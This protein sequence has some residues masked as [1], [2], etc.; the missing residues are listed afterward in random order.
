MKLD[1]FLLTLALG[2]LSVFGTFA[3]DTATNA[4]SAEEPAIAVTNVTNAVNEAP[5]QGD[6]RRGRD[7]KV[8]GRNVELRASESADN[9]LVIGGSARIRGKVENKVIVIGGDIDVD[10]DVGNDVVAVFGNVRAGTNAH[11]HS[12]VITAPGH[13]EIEEGAILNDQPIEF[14]LF[15][16][17]SGLQKWLRYCGFLLRPMAP[18]V[19]WVWLVAL[20]LALVYFLI[21]CLFRA[22]VQACVAIMSARP[23]TTF[24]IGFLTKLLLPLIIGVLAVTGIGLVVAPLVVVALIFGTLVGKTALFEYFGSALGRR[25]NLQWLQNPGMAFLG[26]ILIVIVLYNIPVIGLITFVLTG[27]WGLG[28]A[29][30]AAFETLRK[31]IPRKTSPAPGTISSESAGSDVLGGAPTVATPGGSIPAVEGLG[32]VASGLDVRAGFMVRILAAILDIILIGIVSYPFRRHPI[33]MLIGL[34]YFCVFWMWRGTTIGGLLL[35]LK[36]RRM[37]G[38]RLSFPVTL[39]RA[40]AAAFSVFVMFLGFLWIIWDKDKQG[41]HDKIAGTVVVRVPAGRSL[42]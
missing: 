27:I 39:V 10:S 26:G 6:Y 40:L 11:L 25:F 8:I 1:K 28:G 4:P 23:A 20:V 22:P 31:E 16:M 38:Q 13:A 14:D 15:G 17:G 2:W 7:I 21:S 5:E 42:I 18:Q 24:L 35:N 32:V 33:G 29:A 30:S 3:Q 37:D 12:K 19:G 36:V 41:W 34:V 9:V